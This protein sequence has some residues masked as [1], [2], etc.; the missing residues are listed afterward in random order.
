MVIAPGV[1]KLIGEY[2][3]W[4]KQFEFREEEEV[5]SVDEVAARVASFY[6]KLREIVDWRGEHLLRKT[7]IERI[8]KRRLTV[9]KVHED[10]AENFLAELVR[11][12]HFPNN[13]ISFDQVDEIQAVIQKY[14]FIAERFR[15]GQQRNRKNP[16]DWLFSIAAVEIEEALSKPRREHALIELMTEDLENRTQLVVRKQDTERVLPEGEKRLQIYVAVQRALFKLDP[17]TTAYHILEKFYPDWKVPTQETLAYV[18]GHLEVLHENIQKILV[19][20]YGERFYQLAEKYD[21]PYLILHDILSDD[22][23]RFSELINN[24]PTFEEAIRH[25]YNARHAR[26]KRRIGRAALYSVLSVF[27]TKVLIAFLIEIPVDRYFQQGINYLAIGLSVAIPSF[28]MMVLIFTAK[29][30]SQRNFER[31]M[32]EVIKII[33]PRQRTEPFKI[34]PPHRKTGLLASIVYGF[35]LLSFL[36]SFGALIWGLQELR[37]SPSSIVIFLMFISLVLFGGT[38]IR[39]QARELMIEPTRE[40]FLYNIFD[41]FSLPMIQ[42]GRWLSGQIVRYNVFLLVLNFLVE[43]PFQMFVEFLE[44]WRGLLR[45]KK[46][47]IH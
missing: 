12:G 32:M 26:L 42:V 37:F 34:F 22:S 8:L 25:S 10:F 43:V 41:I 9:Q 7:A 13:R 36:L 46:E 30:T 33:Q 21:T 27:I 47:E 17:T 11:G 39:Q 5:I 23:T 3:G 24:P 40:G 4:R 18:G 15:E 31:V 19:H 6:E 16:T 20:P 38:R 14:V 35:Y 1:Q 2:D 28:L 44:Q 45:E 29:T